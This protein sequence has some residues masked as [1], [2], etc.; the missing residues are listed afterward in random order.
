MDHKPSKKDTVILFITSA[1]EQF[2][3]WEEKKMQKLWR[4]CLFCASSPVSLV[5][6]YT[7]PRWLYRNYARELPATKNFKY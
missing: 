1:R 5:S 7:L 4:N 2:K 3:I 6:V